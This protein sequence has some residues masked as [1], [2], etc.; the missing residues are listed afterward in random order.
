EVMSKRRAGKETAQQTDGSQMAARD[1]CASLYAAVNVSRVLTEHDEDHR[2]ALVTGV[3]E[4]VGHAGG[5]ED[6]LVVPECDLSPAETCPRGARL[7]DDEKRCEVVDLVAW[8]GID[9][10]PRRDP[11]PACAQALGVVD[12]KGFAAV[13]RQR[14]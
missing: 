9:V 7:D 14:T 6:R 11:V 5:D 3:P 13:R 8:I 4:F 1:H 12:G 2:R 10:L